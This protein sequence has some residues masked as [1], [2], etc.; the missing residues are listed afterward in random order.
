MVRTDWVQLISGINLESFQ[1]RVWTFTSTSESC[2]PSNT[3]TWYIHNP[4]PSYSFLTYCAFRVAYTVNMSLI[5]PTDPENI[6]PYTEIQRINKVLVQLCRANA[7]HILLH[8]KQLE[9]QLD[10]TRYSHLRTSRITSKPNQLCLHLQFFYIHDLDH[11]RP[12][13]L[14]HSKL[15]PVQDWHIHWMRWLGLLL[16]C[17]GFWIFALTF[18]LSHL[19]S[20]VS[21]SKPIKTNLFLV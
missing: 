13:M 1:I 5:L 19:F 2:A 11:E 15:H 20:P 16:R 17:F 14:S 10:P 21:K 9:L 6:S 7:S 3:F 4:I 12:C 18:E 8:S